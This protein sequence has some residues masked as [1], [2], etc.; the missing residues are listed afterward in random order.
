MHTVII[1]LDGRA[2]AHDANR[3]RGSFA[4]AVAGIEATRA[5]GVPVRVNTVLNSNNRAEVEWL[6]EFAG[7][8]DLPLTLNIMRSG[9]AE[10]YNDAGRH[11]IADTAIR[12][13]LTHVIELR[14]ANPHIVFSAA[15]YR[16]LRRWADFTKDRL[17]PEQGG[18]R[19]AQR[20]VRPGGFI[21]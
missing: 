12:E 14:R 18:R 5:W 1:S 21:T 10:L 8:R 11:R 17:T 15:T 16:I 20:V 4:G 13:L 3:G 2:A 6:V 9:S 19:A 7:R